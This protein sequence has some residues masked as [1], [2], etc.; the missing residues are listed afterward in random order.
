MVHLFRAHI[1]AS[2]IAKKLD[3]KEGYNILQP[4]ELMTFALNKFAILQKQN[5]W[6][7]KSLEEEHVIAHSLAW[8]RN[9]QMQI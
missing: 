2:N 3:H 8:C 6:N 9:Y 1:K 7:T 4:E 5:L